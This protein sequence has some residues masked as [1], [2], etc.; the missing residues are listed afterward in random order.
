MAE[1]ESDWCVFWE[2]RGECG[3][4][5]HSQ[6]EEEGSAA[7]GAE[8]EGEDELWQRAVEKSL[9]GHFVWLAASGNGA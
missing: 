4:V 7:D 3:S 9:A 6:G 8:G 1:A 2:D 5:S